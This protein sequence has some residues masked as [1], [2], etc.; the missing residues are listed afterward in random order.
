MR[1]VFSGKV[2]SIFVIPGAGKAVM[3]SHGN[4]RTVYA[5]LQEVYVK[6]GDAV[7]AKQE[8]GA[9]LPSQDGKISEAHFEIWSISNGDMQKLNPA[10]WLSR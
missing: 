4:Y 6:K 5:N 10:Y 2:S 9:L 8:V 7:E 3:I 1:A